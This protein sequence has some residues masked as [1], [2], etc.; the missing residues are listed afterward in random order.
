M[1]DN[2]FD[3]QKTFPLDFFPAVRTLCLSGFRN[4]QMITQDHSH[5]HLE[6]LSFSNCPQ[7]ESLPGSMHILLPSLKELRIDDCPRVES[8][9]EGGLL[10]LSLTYL[11]ISNFPNLKKLD[12]KGLYQ[13]SSLKKLILLDCPNLQQLPEE[14]LPNSISYLNIGGCPNLKQRCQNPGGEDW[15]KIAHIPTM[16]ISG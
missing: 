5:N 4:L 10:P 7:L 9:P 11:R 12:Y 3:S 2:G 14:G 8:F 13:L 15:P 6:V 16:D 1:S